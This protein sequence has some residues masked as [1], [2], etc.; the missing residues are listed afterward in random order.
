MCLHVYVHTHRMDR[1]DPQRCTAANTALVE[2]H[3]EHDVLED[4]NTYSTVDDMRQRVIVTPEN[5]AY[6]K[7]LEH[8]QWPAQQHN[9]HGYST[10]ELS[11]DQ[12]MVKGGPQAHGAVQLKEA[13]SAK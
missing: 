4:G 10:I 13:A 12:E 3:L 5:S 1:T 11:Q 6:G 9:D 8:S 7:G 2:S